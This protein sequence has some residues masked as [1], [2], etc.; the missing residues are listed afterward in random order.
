V[1]DVNDTI[2]EAIKNEQLDAT[3]RRVKIPQD[4]CY[5]LVMTIQLI[6]LTPEC[7]LGLV[8]DG[9]VVKV[10]FSI[11]SG[12]NDVIRH[13]M[14]CSLCNLASSRDCREDLVDQGAIELLVILS[15]S[16]YPDTQ[17]QCATALG[18]LSEN[19]MVKNGTCASLLLLSLK[20]EE[21]KESLSMA[22]NGQRT[23]R[24][25]VH[26]EQSIASAHTNVSAPAKELLAL[27]NVKSL[28]VMIRDGLNRHQETHGVTSTVDDTGTIDSE[29]VETFRGTSLEDLN[30]IGYA[31]LTPYE[32]EV[33]S[34]DYSKYEY[35]ITTHPVSQEG[36]GVSLKTR[37]ELPYPSVSVNAAET[38]RTAVGE[39]FEMKVSS[40]SLPKNE[41]PLKVLDGRT[42]TVLGDNTNEADDKFNP[43]LKGGKKSGNARQEKFLSRQMSSADEYIKPPGLMF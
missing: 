35:A 37:V 28:T 1:N 25:S 9:A 23:K 4:S 30:A 41:D 29:S 8:E 10:F 3:A 43:K 36:G 22:A 16:P 2:D 21:M 11:L 24:V 31:E 5:D 17:A 19:T 14:V 34:R 6:S 33:L 32:H 27:Q 7:R 26:D 42:T 12:L 40:E 38:E 20:S 39:L 18:Y 13:E 15:D